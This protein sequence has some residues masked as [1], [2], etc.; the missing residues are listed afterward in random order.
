MSE[1]TEPS[2]FVEVSSTLVCE[3]S[4]AAVNDV[5]VVDVDLK[6]VLSVVAEFGISE[7]C[8]GYGPNELT[9]AF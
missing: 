5:P 1:T 4:V 2:S 3:E 6:D 7:V 8:A 9:N